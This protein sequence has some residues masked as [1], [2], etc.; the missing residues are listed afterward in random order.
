MTEKA[1]KTILATALFAALA[2]PGQAQ[3]GDTLR[4][5]FVGNSF[6]FY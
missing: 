3:Q 6:T 2:L 1:L 4:V 5:L